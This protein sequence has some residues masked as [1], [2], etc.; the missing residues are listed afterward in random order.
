MNDRLDFPLLGG[1]LAL[2]LVNTR[3]RRRGTD[4]DLIDTP[5]TL[6]AWLSAQHHRVSGLTGITAADVR[7]VC[8]LR[9][10][11]SAL[12]SAWQGGGR[13]PQ[14]ALATVNDALAGRPPVPRLTW[15]VAGPQVR[16]D[17]ATTCSGDLL[18]ALA[19]DAVTLISGEDMRLV[20]SCEHP[21]CALRFLAR[22]PRRRWC[23]AAGCGNRARVARHYARHG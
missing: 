13:P 21:G 10:A 4:T 2:D 12:L 15:G 17:P 5:A 8:E 14:R 9:E 20:R 7:A 22:N 16:S 1:S 11:I 23:C 19:L 18:R 3:V 6:G